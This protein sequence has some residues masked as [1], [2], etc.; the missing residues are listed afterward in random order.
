MSLTVFLDAGPLGLI[1]NSKRTEDTLAV[2]RWIIAMRTAGRRFVVPAIAGFEVRCELIRAGKPRG[3][4]QL[5]AFNAATPG[6]FLSVT[7]RTLLLAAEFWAQARNAGATTA[8]PTKLN[9]DVLIA[10]QAIDTGIP[11]SDF[12]IATSNLGH[13]SLFAPA[14]LWNQIN[15]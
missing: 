14:N 3:I 10:A 9:A 11:M 1:T 7:D 6:R 15:P 8:D 5:D 2:T 13:L 12:V 4:A